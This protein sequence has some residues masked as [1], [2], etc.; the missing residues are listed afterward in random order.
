MNHDEFDVVVIGAGF[1]GLTAAR[2][3][4]RNGQKVLLAEARDRIGGR[5]WTDHRLGT[6]LE[7]GGTW[8]HWAQPHVWS[9][10]TRYGIAVTRSPAPTAAHWFAGGELHHGTMSEM[11]EVLGAGTAELLKD[12]PH[13]FPRPFNIEVTDEIRDL[14]KKTIQEV[15]DGMELSA[16]QRELAEGLWASNF[17]GRPEEGAYSQAL[18]WAALASGNLDLLWDT[19]VVYKLKTGM[20]SL[21]EAIL[22]DSTA[23][24]RLSTVVTQINDDG[25]GVTVE[26]DSGTIRAKAVVVTI[27]IPA[28]R[29]VQ[30]TPDLPDAIKSVS[31]EGHAGRG[32]K[33]WARVKG[34]LEPFQ[35]T[36]GKDKPIVTLLFDKHVDGDSLVVG[37]GPDGRA[38]DPNNAEEVQDIL[39]LWFPDVEVVAATG[40]GWVDD[41]Y[42]MA[43]YAM[44]KPGQLAGSLAELESQS[45][46]VI[47][48]GSDYA[49]GW[50]GFVDG[51][52]AS[53]LAAPRRL[54]P[55]L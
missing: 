23:E 5:T 34:E 20:K 39:R 42:S 46:R 26:T 24:L 44:Y 17:N 48:T 29:S 47:L 28:L 2:E 12:G 18:R 4:A 13:Y 43:T 25:N 37:F 54:A 11:W 30:F 53:G 51:A 7:M 52:I 21:A 32:M 45:G 22:A 35:A 41:P 15:L 1:T 27:P 55:W 6:Q 16:D 9:E 31:E 33:V 10:I 19:L 8:V 50:G 3:L 14:D 38:F 40:H 36:A 49:N